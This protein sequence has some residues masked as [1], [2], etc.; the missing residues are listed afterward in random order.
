MSGLLYQ[1]LND[2]PNFHF[3]FNFLVNLTEP[4]AFF[5]SLEYFEHQWSHPFRINRPP[6]LYDFIIQGP[7]YHYREF[8][9]NLDALLDQT[10]Q[11]S[12]AVCGLYDQIRCIYFRTRTLVLR[13]LVLLGRLG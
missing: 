2:D 9:L 1:H 4:T 3:L 13:K 5:I 8:G 6:G 7:Q 11:H 10:A 12:V